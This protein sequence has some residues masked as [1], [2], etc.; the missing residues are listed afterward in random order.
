[1]SEAFTLQTFLEDIKTS[2]PVS[3][4]FNKEKEDLIIVKTNTKE[5]HID[6]ENLEIFDDNNKL[7]FTVND[8]EYHLIVSTLMK[9]LID[10]ANSGEDIHVI[11]S[12]N[13]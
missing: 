3:F 7:L 5:Y 12:D 9:P 6:K 8:D 2:E 10:L 4:E 11:V 13:K 1:M